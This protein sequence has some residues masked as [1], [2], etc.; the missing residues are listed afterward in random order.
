EAAL[1]RL[2]PV[3]PER[4]R[5]AVDLDLVN[6]EL[7]FH[8]AFLSKV[9]AVGGRADY[10]LGPPPLSPLRSGRRSGGLGDSDEGR[11]DTHRERHA[12]L[13][14]GTNPV[15]SEVRVVRVRRL[16]PDATLTV[17]RGRRLEGADQGRTGR[18]GGRDDRPQTPQR[19]LP[20]HR[21]VAV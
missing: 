7:V 4:V 2:L 10:L 17:D 11:R 3:Q 1:L 20:V 16:H 15:V 14:A 12:L 21:A 18:D 8:R 13:E 19:G 5:E 6:P 9:G